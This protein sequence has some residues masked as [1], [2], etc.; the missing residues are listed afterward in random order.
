M[1]DAPVRQIQ[2]GRFV[3]I[4]RRIET[5]NSLVGGGQ[6]NRDL[7]LRLKG[8]QDPDPFSYY[9]TD[10]FGN[11]GW[12]GAFGASGLQHSAGL[13]PDPGPTAGIVN[14]L[15][16]DGSWATPPGGGGSGDVIS[17]VGLSVDTEIAVFAGTTGKHLK[18]ATGTGIA[19][20]TSG[21]LST[22]TDN[23]AIW[24]NAVLGP[25]SSIDFSYPLWD[26]HI[27]EAFTEPELP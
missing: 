11:R 26:G 25:V 17:D 27:R 24:N 2:H 8:D 6:L 1:P 9:G 12:F 14:F 5:D 10:I 23:S 22:I 7:Q 13:V 16:E 4:T 15:R 21:V 20:V 3:P 19:K 18:R